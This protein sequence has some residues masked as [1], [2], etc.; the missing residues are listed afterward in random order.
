MNVIF[1]IYNS[2]QSLPKIYLVSSLWSFGIVGF[3]STIFSMLGISL[4]DINNSSFV[5]NLCNLFFFYILFFLVSFAFLRTV[6]KDSISLKIAMTNVLVQ[7]GDIFES[8]GFKVIGCDNHFNVK[9]DDIVISKKSLHGRFLL[10]HSNY[11]D[12]KRQ[13]EATA[14]NMKLKKSSE[15]LYEFPL[16]TIIKYHSK[17]DNQTYL[18]LAMTKLD[19]DYKSRTT[20]A[21]Y[22]QMLINMWKEIDRV[23]ASNDIV[24]PLLGSGISRFEDGPKSNGSLLRCILCTFN[25]SGVRLN[26]TVKIVLKETKSKYLLYD[27]KWMFDLISR[28]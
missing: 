13:I 20:M 7:H 9:A 6:Y 26:S 16:G 28:I 12:L 5:L 19:K 22:E 4:K 25:S 23:Y 11:N 21:E 17:V 18:L 2:I 14:R 10:E 15:G 8:K 3:L 24:L 1:K 27:F